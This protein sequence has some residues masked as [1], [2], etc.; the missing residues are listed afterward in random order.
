MH[1]ALFSLARERRER[2]SLWK[3]LALPV[4][5]DGLPGTLA[6][7]LFK[8]RL[9]SFALAAINFPTNPCIWLLNPDRQLATWDRLR[10]FQGS[11]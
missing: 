4:L 7:P 2:Q 3:Y 8:L 9:F 6:S 11:I 5:I 10:Q 1:L